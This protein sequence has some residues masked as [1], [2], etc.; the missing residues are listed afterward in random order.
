[1]DQLL[2]P[3][4]A[5]KLIG[6]TVAA[7]IQHVRD[8]ELAYINIG[9]GEKKIRRRFKLADIEAFIQRRTRTDKP[10]GPEGEPGGG[11]EESRVFDLKS[12]RSRRKARAISAKVRS[13]VPA[14]AM[15]PC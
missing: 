2:K 13:M 12:A 15:R 7:L 10:P 1:M 8:G 3:P 14:A 9:R 11:S 4:E 5:A 6:I